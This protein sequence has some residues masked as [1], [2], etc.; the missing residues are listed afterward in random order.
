[1]RTSRE[2]APLFEKGPGGQESSETEQ[3][4]TSDRV[5]I[6]ISGIVPILV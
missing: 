5:L 4:G 6:Y 3:M 2:R 1:M